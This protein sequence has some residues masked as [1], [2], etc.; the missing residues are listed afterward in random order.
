MKMES[1]EQQIATRPLANQN[2]NSAISNQA[3]AQTDDN[4]VKRSISTDAI[5]R[6]ISWPKN[7][8]IANIVF[9]QPIQINEQE[10]AALWVMLPQAEI[11]QRLQ[12]RTYNQF[13]F[14]TTPY[15]MML[16]L[17][18]LYHRTYGAKWLPYYLDLKT[19]KGQE[20]T[21]LMAEK[22]YYRVLLFGRESPHTA[23]T[24]LLSNIAPTQRQLLQ[25]ERTLVR[26]N[27]R[28]SAAKR[29][30]NPKA[31]AQSHPADPQSSTYRPYSPSHP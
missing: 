3:I 11:F 12:S 2:F 18:V 21:Q 4:S 26:I 14:I 28:H 20:I 25:L 1:L 7:K 30:H 10:I 6:L 19:S 24:C 27:Q 17:T 9:P 8:P 15:P 23:S 13:L 16:W 31:Q 5:C 29:Q 22:G